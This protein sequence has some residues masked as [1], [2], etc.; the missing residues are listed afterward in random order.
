MTYIPEDNV[1]DELRR[2]GNGRQGFGD[3]HTVL[4]IFSQLDPCVLLTEKQV[5]AL[6]SLSVWTVRSWRQRSIRL[7]PP[8]LKIGAAVRYPVGGLRRYLEALAVA[9]RSGGA[10]QQN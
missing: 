9:A 7:G 1:A 6:L 10:S 5:A 3:P 8:S 2:F 4:P